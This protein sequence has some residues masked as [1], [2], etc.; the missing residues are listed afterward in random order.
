MQFNGPQSHI[1]FVGNLWGPCRYRIDIECDAAAETLILRNH[2][3]FF[4]SDN[5]SGVD[6][7]DGGRSFRT[8]VNITRT[9]LNLHQD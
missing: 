1:L 9:D 6:V 2:S 5:S 7:A 3:L 4:C 8:I